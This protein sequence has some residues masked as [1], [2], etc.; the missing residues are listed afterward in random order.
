MGNE[1]GIP[2]AIV[3]KKRLD[4]E[5]E[6]GYTIYIPDGEMH[7]LRTFGRLGMRSS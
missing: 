4:R 6:F 7:V 1:T 3:L 2:A 5:P